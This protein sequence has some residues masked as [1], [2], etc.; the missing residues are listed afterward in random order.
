MALKIQIIS[1]LFSFLYGI[2]F[3]LLVIIGYRFLFL[4]N[5]IFKIFFTFCFMFITS[6]IYFCIINY[7]ND[8]ILHYYFFLLFLL[9]CNFSKL[10]KCFR[11][12]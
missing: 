6:F 7:I 11:G 10:I 8:G 2:F 12:K 5:R 1:M 3:K 9:G 4:S